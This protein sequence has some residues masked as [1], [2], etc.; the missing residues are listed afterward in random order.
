MVITQTPWLSDQA[1]IHP[2]F[3][4]QRPLAKPPA[5]HLKACD[6]DRPFERSCQAQ[7]EHQGS[8][9]HPRPCSQHIEP[10]GFKRANEAIKLSKACLDAS[11]R[12]SLAALFNLDK[13]R[14]HDAVHAL[15]GVGGWRCG[16]ELLCEP[17]TQLDR[18]SAWCLTAFSHLQGCKAQISEARQLLDGLS[19]LAGMGRD[20][21]THGRP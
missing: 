8:L 12:L 18:I 17:G 13:D 3:K 7:L 20:C 4:R 2:G 10:G 9:T 6:V 16:V 14:L 1:S 15:Q 5:C 21:A 19:V 11:W